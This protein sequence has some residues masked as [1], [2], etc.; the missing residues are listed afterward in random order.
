[1]ICTSHLQVT[2]F[3]QRAQFYSNSTFFFFF[4]FLINRTNEIEIGGEPVSFHVVQQKYKL[5]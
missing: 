5:Y 3:M 4:F 1:M 2:L